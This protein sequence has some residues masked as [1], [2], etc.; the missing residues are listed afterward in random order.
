MICSDLLVL[1]AWKMFTCW[2]DAD[3]YIL[4]EM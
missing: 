4:D 2:F 1:S 3:I